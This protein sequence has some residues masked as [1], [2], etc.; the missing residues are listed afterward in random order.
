MRVCGGGCTGTDMG[1][2]GGIN[3]CKR[4]RRSS[5]TNFCGQS[6]GRYAICGNGGV[7]AAGTCVFENGPR[8]GQGVRVVIQRQVRNLQRCRG[9]ELAFSFQ[10]CRYPQQVCGRC[11]QRL[12]RPDGPHPLLR[13]VG[14]SGAAKVRAGVRLHHKRTLGIFSD[15]GRDNGRHGYDACA[16]CNSHGGGGGGK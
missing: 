16:R 8:T 4:S 10:L 11:R 9:G 13:G 14:V 2:T 12:R 7:H 1:H 15:L 5:R 3:T 6:G